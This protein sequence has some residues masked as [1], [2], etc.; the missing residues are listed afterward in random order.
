[1]L[2]KDKKKA[3][4]SLLLG[5]ITFKPI[6]LRKPT[7]GKKSALYIKASGCSRGIGRTDSMTGSLSSGG[8]GGTGFSLYLFSALVSSISAKK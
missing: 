5:G 3:L 7:F 4:P 8:S 2:Q 1:M 6:V